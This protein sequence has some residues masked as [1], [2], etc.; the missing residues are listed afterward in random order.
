LSFP[1]VRFLHPACGT[2]VG[3]PSNKN[4]LINHPN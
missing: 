1:N 2:F 3:N 4:L